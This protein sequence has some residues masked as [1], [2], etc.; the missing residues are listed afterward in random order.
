ML[1]GDSVVLQVSEFC[2]R[3]E[4]QKDAPNVEVGAL[5]VMRGLNFL[6]SFRQA[7]TSITSMER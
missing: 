2:R 1:S 7:K 3:L 4:E 6:L 5:F